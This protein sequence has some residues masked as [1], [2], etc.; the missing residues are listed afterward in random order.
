MLGKIVIYILGIATGLL[1]AAVLHG[2]MD[3]LYDWLETKKKSR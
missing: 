2:V 3:K 1:A